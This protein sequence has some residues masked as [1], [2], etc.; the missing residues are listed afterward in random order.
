MLVLQESQG[1]VEKRA[2]ILEDSAMSSIRKNAQLGVW[3]LARQ[4]HRIDRWHHYVSV[5]VRHQHRVLDTV[6]RGRLRRHAPLGNRGHLSNDGL[7]CCRQIAVLLSSVETLEKFRS[8][9]LAVMRLCEKERLLR[10]FLLGCCPGHRVL[11]HGAHIADPFAASGRSA[12]QNYFSHK[13][14]MLLRDDL[15][16]ETTE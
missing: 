7:L 5:A 10:M 1:L 4:L 8:R 9:L 6:Q 11:Q 13:I 16:D 3:Q 2:V 14:G 12:S 15:S